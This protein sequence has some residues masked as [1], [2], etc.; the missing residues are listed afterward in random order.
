[1]SQAIKENGF[2]YLE[3]EFPPA[4]LRSIFKNSFSLI[5]VTVSVS[6]KELSS[7][8]DGFH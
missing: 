4:R 6:R 8:V 3:N 5:L 7:K 2:H 1:M